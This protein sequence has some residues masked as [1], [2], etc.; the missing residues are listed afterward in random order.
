MLCRPGG[1][2]W[3]FFLVP[4]DISAIF[5][6]GSRQPGRSR[7]KKRVKKICWYRASAWRL[8]CTS[9][10]FRRAPQALDEKDAA[11]RLFARDC[12]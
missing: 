5:M 11:K 8:P 9:I 4:A 7:G 10:S 6:G 2:T 3:E 1:A 12:A